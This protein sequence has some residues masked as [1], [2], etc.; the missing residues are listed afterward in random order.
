MC[1]QVTG[2]TAGREP[3]SGTDNKHLLHPNVTF[4]VVKV[5]HSAPGLSQKKEVSPGMSDCYMKEYK[6]KFVKGVSCVTHLSYVKPVTNV[7]NAASNL[8]VGARLQNF[9]KLGWIWVPVQK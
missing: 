2:T 7:Q 5:V 8:P 1:K 4:P 6:L 3:S 9:G